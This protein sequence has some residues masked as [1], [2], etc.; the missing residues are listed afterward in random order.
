MRRKNFY[1]KGGDNNQTPPRT[2]GKPKNG[3]VI[4]TVK[5]G[6][7]NKG[8]GTVTGNGNQITPLQQ[9]IE[10]GTQPS[11]LKPNFI[12]TAQYELPPDTIQ[13]GYCP[14]C[15]SKTCPVCQSYEEFKKHYEQEQLSLQ[16]QKEKEENLQKLKN[17]MNKL[18]L[19]EGFTN[20]EIKNQLLKYQPNQNKIKNLNALQKLPPE[21][22]KGNKVSLI[23][24]LGLSNDFTNQNLN[25]L[26]N[27]L[28]PKDQ[29]NLD[30]LQK[31]Q[32]INKNSR[33]YDKL[34]NKLYASSL[35]PVNN[36]KTSVNQK[37]NVTVNQPVN[38]QSN[39][40]N[41]SNDEAEERLIK[42]GINLNGTPEEIKSHIEDKIKELKQT[43]GNKKDIELLNSL[44]IELSNQQPVNQPLKNQVLNMSN[45]EAEERLIKMGINLEGT[46]EEIK[47][48]IEDKIKELKQTNGNKRNISLLNT[49]L[50]EISN[51]QGG[52]KKKRQKK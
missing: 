14:K 18:G 9:K 6:T 43:N 50:S 44:L 15:E 3:N 32:S 20:D 5:N 35:K 46:P 27:Q 48:H 47:S 38:Q 37:P 42:M 36:K 21:L 49:L 25:Q 16:V 10:N 31:L 17:Q 34:V 12:E 4:G 8:N 24:N 22:R 23:K 45:D 7:G 13:C 19:K 33:T 52:N 41:M 30:L 11:G 28:K 39:Q 1:K 51:Q 26:K 2:N 40:T 29:E